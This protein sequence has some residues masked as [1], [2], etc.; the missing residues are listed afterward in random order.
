MITIRENLKYERERHPWP[1]LSLSHAH[2]P[3]SSPTTPRVSFIHFLFS[4]QYL[5]YLLKLSWDVRSQGSKSEGK[6]EGAREGNK[7]HVM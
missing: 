1:Q 7:P 3:L 4:P 2:A 6:G 5:V